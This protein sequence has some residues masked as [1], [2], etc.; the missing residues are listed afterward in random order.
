MLEV[1][2]SSLC[3]VVVSTLI[4]FTKDQFISILT[5]YMNNFLI[6]IYLS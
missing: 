4:Y 2:D 5:N 1:E 6:V 3:I